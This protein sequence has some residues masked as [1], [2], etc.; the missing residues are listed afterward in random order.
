M[1]LANI[2]KLC[3][4]LENISAEIYYLTMPFY[5]DLKIKEL[6]NQSEVSSSFF[7]LNT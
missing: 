1:L 4:F 5:L 6:R 7:L 3:Y 2:T